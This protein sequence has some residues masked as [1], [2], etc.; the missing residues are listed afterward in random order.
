MNNETEFGDEDRL[1]QARETIARQAEEIDRLHRRLADER[2]AEG[3]REALALAATA[4]R[5]ASPV[6]HS[7]LLE[8]IVRTAAHVIRARY[9]SLFLIDQETHELVFEVSLRETVEELQK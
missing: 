6:T 1:A 3:L 9:G 7:R 8:M 5:I 2:F 4:G